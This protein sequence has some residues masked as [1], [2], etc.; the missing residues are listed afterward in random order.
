MII[1]LLTLIMCISVT[2][3]Y[4][5]SVSENILDLDPN[6]IAAASCN[7]ALIAGSMFNYE[8]GI[9]S[10]ERARIM[11]RSTTLAFWITA[12]KHQSIEHLRK[13]AVDYDEFVSDSY[14]SVYDD[15][16]DGNYT[17][18]S[19]AEMDVC[20]A[21]ILDPLTSV[22]AEDLKRSGIDNYDQFRA[23]LFT[24]ADKRFDYMLKLIEAMR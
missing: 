11:L 14:E 12:T 3:V 19:Q 18:E 21:R 9:L 7:G 22:S 6:I 15:L 10:E 17:W 16:I 2:P 4:A 1:R 23:M 24:E 20:T 13:Y 8:N 5:K